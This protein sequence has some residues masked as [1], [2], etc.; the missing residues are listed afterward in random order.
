MLM[1]LFQAWLACNALY[2]LMNRI[3]HARNVI[4]FGLVVYV[5]LRL[6]CIEF[7]GLNAIILPSAGL[8]NQIRWYYYRPEPCSSTIKIIE[9]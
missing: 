9:D 6:F 7:N 3:A 1:N 4:S 2:N 5:Y 8:Q